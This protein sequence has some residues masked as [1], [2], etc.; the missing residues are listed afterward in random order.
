MVHPPGH[1][2]QGTGHRAQGTGHRA[3]GTDFGFAARNSPGTVNL[4]VLATCDASST[5][6][7][8]QSAPKAIYHSYLSES[9]GGP[10]PTWLSEGG[11]AGGGGG[12]NRV[13]GRRPAKMQPAGAPQAREGAHRCDRRAFALG[14]RAGER[15]WPRAQPAGG[16]RTRRR[17]RRPEALRRRG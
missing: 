2:A 7:E 1:R 16:G 9:R 8:P 11:W 12:K 4:A 17:V 3:L 13:R 14:G 5:V 10:G 6:D 15:P